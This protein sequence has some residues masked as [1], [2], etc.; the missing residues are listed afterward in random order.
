MKSFKNLY[1]RR[2]FLFGILCI[3]IPILLFSI[4]SYSIFTSYLDEQVLQSNL[5]NISQVKKR[6]DAELEFISKSTKNLVGDS[7]LNQLIYN[8]NLKNENDH[9]QSIHTKLRDIKKSIKDSYSIDLYIPKLE[10]II[11]SEKGVISPLSNQLLASYQNVEAN[12]KP[13]WDYYNEQGAADLLA[14]YQPLP[15]ISNF[16]QAYLTVHTYESAFSR[17]YGLDIYQTVGEMYILNRSGKVVSHS[18]KKFLGTYLSNK[19]QSALKEIDRSSEQDNYYTDQETKETYFYSKS[20]TSDLIAVY[21]IDNDRLFP[22]RK[23]ASIF[24]VLAF[25]LILLGSIYIF[26]QANKLLKPMVLYLKEMNVPLEKLNKEEIWNILRKNRKLLL[27]EIFSLE[28]WKKKNSLELEKYSWLKLLHGPCEM[29]TSKQSIDL[30]SNQ[31]N[32]DKP[33]RVIF[34][35]PYAGLSSQNSLLHDK[36]LML[37]AIRNIGGEVLD[38][39]NIEGFIVEAIENNGIVLILWLSTISEE[40]YHVETN[41]VIAL[42]QQSFYSTLKIAACIG[43]GKVYF[44]LDGINKSFNEA[45]E[46]LKEKYIK[47]DQKI[48][49]YEEVE[50]TRPFSYPYQIESELIKELKDNNLENTLQKFN[51]WSIQI[52]NNC[53]N[54]QMIS[55][56]YFILFVS[57]KRILDEISDNQFDLFYEVP[58]R[59]LSHFQSFIAFKAWFENKVV[60][61]VLNQIKTISEKKGIK[62]VEFVKSYMKEHIYEDHTLTSAAEKVG[63]SSAYLSRLFK[64]ITGESFLNYLS[65]IKVEKSKELLLQT[66]MNISEIAVKIGYSERTYGRLFKKI[67]GTTPNNFRLSHSKQFSEKSKKIGGG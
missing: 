38:Q 41:Q 12:R 25:S 26:Y 67:T 23:T 8:S 11:S 53:K 50:T 62:A 46:A 33:Y 51:E 57:F 63:L 64:K 49:Y 43:I 16:P 60:I 54:C 56:A 27:K 29:G 14:Y 10:M 44:S 40:N 31:L 32:F 3:T 61:F 17:I 20:T 52:E 48:Y 4:V 42:L 65:H 13:V 35:E 2:I 30:L 37:F 1:F 28:K 34:I 18:N 36:G 5:A 45:T 22:H 9:I 15:V 47:A 58:F 7:D 55:D 6:M 39:K 66:D 24:F 59:K 21:R 19:Y